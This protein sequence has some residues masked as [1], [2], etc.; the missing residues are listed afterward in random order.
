MNI[1]QNRNLQGGGGRIKVKLDLSNYAT[2]ANLINAAGAD[3]SK[4]PQKVDLTSLKSN[5]II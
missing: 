2:I 1:F 4:V 5:Y 3:A